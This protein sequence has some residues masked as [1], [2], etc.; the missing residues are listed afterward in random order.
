MWASGVKAAGS[1]KSRFSLKLNS[2]FV[3]TMETWTKLFY[4]A[5]T[6]DELDEC[7]IATDNF[8]TASEAGYYSFTASASVKSLNTPG[9]FLIRFAIN[10]AQANKLDVEGQ[11]GAPTVNS[12]AYAA[13]TG[14]CYLD[15]GDEVE[16]QVYVAG[17]SNETVGERNGNF[18]GHRF[19]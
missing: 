8:F 13:I 11:A 9:E 14:E 10:G 19:A 1:F 2:G 7:D 6:Y 12:H 4:H 17:T 18:Q 15:A 16:V 5:I 3:V